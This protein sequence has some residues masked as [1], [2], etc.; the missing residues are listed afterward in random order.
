MEE[1]LALPRWWGTSTKLRGILTPSEGCNLG[2]GTSM[3]K[4]TL[5]L[6]FLSFFYFFGHATWYVTLVSRPG[7]EPTPHY[8]R[9]AES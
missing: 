6:P 2:E 8:S 4:R 7:I 9:C 5:E 3:G 1:L